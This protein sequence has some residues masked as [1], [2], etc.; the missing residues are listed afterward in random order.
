M[1]GLLL[2]SANPPFRA[3]RT[4]AREPGSEPLNQHGAATDHDSCAE[5]PPEPVRQA[6]HVR[7]SR[8]R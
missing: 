7:R 8:R 4:A 3:E 6:E 2:C 1:L 5:K